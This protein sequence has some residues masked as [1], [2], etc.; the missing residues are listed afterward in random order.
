MFMRIRETRHGVLK[1]E[2]CSD[3]QSLR[4]LDCARVRGLERAIVV[5]GESAHARGRNNRAAVPLSGETNASVSNIYSERS[6]AATDGAPS[7]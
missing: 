7:S 6:A 2:R 5:T 4:T 3:L 1:A